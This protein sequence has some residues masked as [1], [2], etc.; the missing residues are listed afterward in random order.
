MNRHIKLW[1]FADVD[2]SGKVRWTANEL[3]YQI[4]EERIRPGD[5]KTDAYRQMNPYEQIPTAEVTGKL[6]VESTAICVMLAE[7]HPEAGLI[8]QDRETRELFWQSMS[9]SSSTLEMPAVLYYLSRAGFIDEAW[10]E[11][12]S[13]SLQRRL[14]T[15]AE[16]MPAAG[17]I[18]D[19]FTLADICAAYSLRIGVQAGLLPMEGRLEAY[20][21]RCMARPAA[22][23]S[24]FFDQLE[25]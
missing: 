17:Y 21:R 1:S 6:L 18:C 2:R 11:L 15:F 20:L 19:E 7:R 23:A 10:Q 9:T 16:S 5:H 22:Q 12:W 13:D 8:P 3:G 24:R 25:A 4:E 14:K